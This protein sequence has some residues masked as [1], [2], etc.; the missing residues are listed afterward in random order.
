MLLEKLM[1]HI[2]FEKN[3][4]TQQ[5]PP[6]LSPVNTQVASQTAAPSAPLHSS[7]ILRQKKVTLLDC[8]EKRMDPIRAPPPTRSMPFFLDESGMSGI[9]SSSYTRRERP[10]HHAEDDRETTL[11]SPT[12]ASEEVTKRKA[13]RPIRGEVVG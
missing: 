13:H 12:V 3:D 9:T 2:H 6:I 8:R 4:V 10:D 11:I 1:P 7:G 5:H